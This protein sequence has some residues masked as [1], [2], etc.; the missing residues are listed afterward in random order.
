VGPR[1]EDVRLVSR[2]SEAELF[3]LQVRPGMTGPMQVHGR[4]ALTFRERLAVEREY[5]ENYSFGK[6]LYLLLRTV[7]AV[8]RGQG[9]F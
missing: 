2:Y 4:G 9:A 3:R 6:D 7:A 1:P 8:F 5:I